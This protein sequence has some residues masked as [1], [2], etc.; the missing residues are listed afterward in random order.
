MGKSVLQSTEY[1]S[2]H[3]KKRICYYER[4]TTPISVNIIS[5]A[6]LILFMFDAIGANE[7]YT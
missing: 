5:F 2:I 4:K 3:V 1:K 6:Y 7:K